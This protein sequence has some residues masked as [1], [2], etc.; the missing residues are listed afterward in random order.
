MSDDEIPHRMRDRLR[1]TGALA[2]AVAGATAR[3][4]VTPK[5]DADRL[6]GEAMVGHLDEMKGMAMKVGQILSY[7]DGALP[8][9][10]QAQLR[11]LQVGS[12]PLPFSVIAQVIAESLGAP[13]DTLFEAL[14]PRP[15][16]SASIGQVHRGVYGGHEVAVKVQYPHVRETFETDTQN[17]H[18][19]ARLASMATRVDGAALV[20]ELHDRLIEECDYAHEAHW[21][22]TFATAF[23]DDPDV[24]VPNVVA[25]RSTDRVLTTTWWQGANFYDFAEVANEATRLRAARTL[26][27]FTWQ[28]FLLH[29]VVQADPHPGN[30]LFAMDGAVVFLDY[31]CI[32]QFPEPFWRTQRD[33]MQVVI[34]DRRA[35]FREALDKTGIVGGRHFDYDF[36]WD[37]LCWQYR[38]Y[39]QA[40]FHFTPEYIAEVQ[41][42][43]GLQNV[44]AMRSVAI[45]PPWIWLQRLQVGLHAVLARL[46]ARGDFRTDML[47]LLAR[48]HGPPPTGTPAGAPR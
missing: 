21:Q 39:R 16:A 25:E 20:E 37:N 46:D 38:P 14:D 19:I 12:E 13:V 29:R 48:A 23:R 2:R 10:T 47:A 9:Q 41:R 6:L 11:R 31:G 43:N 40:V 27:R 18:R 45:P 5:E 4:L 30:Y 42:F 36:W 15:V 28:S 17:L 35:D 26:L 33:V 8:E 7:L 32:K 34:D 44:R 1:K 24:I 22:R 3:R